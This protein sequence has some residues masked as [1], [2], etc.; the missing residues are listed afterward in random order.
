LLLFLF[1]ASISPPGSRS[2]GSNAFPAFCYYFFNIKDQVKIRI[3]KKQ[4]G[5]ATLRWRLAAK[6]GGG[7]RLE[8]LILLLACVN[9]KRGVS[10]G[11]EGVR[12]PPNLLRRRVS[13]ILF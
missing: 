10:N 2:K 12:D 13:F 3:K 4:G 6:Q 5:T 9:K 8:D 11:S 7:Q 1:L